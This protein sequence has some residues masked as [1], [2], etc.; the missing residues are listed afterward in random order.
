MTTTHWAARSLHWKTMGPPLQP[1]QEIVDCF[2]SIIPCSKHI[3][4]M[5]VTPQ[6]ANA[7]A[8][9]TAVDREPAMIANVW[10]GD[11]ATK[12]AINA[13]WLSVDLP[14]ESFDGVIGDGSINMLDISDVSFMFKRAISM[15]KPGGVFACRMFTRPDTPVKL[16]Q[17]YQEA[18]TP[19]VNFSA[20][21]RLLP[22]YLAEVHG[23]VVPVSQISTLF[24]QLCPDRSQVSWTAEQ[25]SKIDDY[26]NSDTTTWFPTRDEILKLSPKGSRFVDVGTYDIADT[27]PI[28]T[29]TK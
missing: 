12:R 18:V 16:D 14:A 5:G 11:T 23:P 24:D 7:Y 8:N 21:R 1:N 15:L 27:C 4:L 25:L 9:V 20:Y 13:N 19:T 3:M 22:M 29:F 6:I 17:L 10:P 26:R 2:H 28:L